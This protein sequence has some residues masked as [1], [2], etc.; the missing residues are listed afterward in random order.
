[1]I[2][3]KGWNTDPQIHIKAVAQFFRGAGSKIIAGPGH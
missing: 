3:D 2:S 1:M